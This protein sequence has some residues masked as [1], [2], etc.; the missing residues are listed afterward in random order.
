MESAV[1][2]TR[3]LAWKP[4]WAVIMFVNVWARSTLDISTAP[5]CVVPVPPTPGVLT[6]FVP[7]VAETVQV[8]PP[9]RSRPDALVNVASGRRESGLRRP[10]AGSTYDTPPEPSMATPVAP[11]GILMAEATEVGV[12]G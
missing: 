11:S 12:V 5:A 4:R 9:L 10:S 6:V 7:E 1:E 3:E 8:L 2:I